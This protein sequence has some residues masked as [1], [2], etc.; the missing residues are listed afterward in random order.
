MATDRSSLSSFE[1]ER[2]SVF[3]S[4][5]AQASLNPLM[6]RDAQGVYVTA[7]DGTTYL[8]FS[9]QLV[10]TNVGHQHPAVVRAISRPGDHAVHHR[11]PAR[12]RVALPRRRADPGP[13]L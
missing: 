1:R 12:L 7:E 8:D 4:W 13:L 3:H 10:N 6:V 11:A 9:S 5:S 2:A